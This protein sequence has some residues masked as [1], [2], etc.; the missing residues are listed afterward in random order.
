ML[1]RTRKTARKSTRPIGVPA[2]NLSQDMKKVAVVATILSGIWKHK[3][4]CFNQNSVTGMI[5]GS[6]MQSSA[7]CKTNSWNEI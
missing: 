1:S 5:Y 3:S 4:N 7:T 6:R 2:I